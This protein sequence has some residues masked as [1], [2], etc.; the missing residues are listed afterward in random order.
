M[1]KDRLL[2]RVRRGEDRDGEALG[3]EEPREETF[4]G[5]VLVDF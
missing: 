1:I 3:E 5:E 4:L 2:I